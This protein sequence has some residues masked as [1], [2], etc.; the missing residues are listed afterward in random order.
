MLKSKLHDFGFDNGCIQ[1]FRSYLYGHSQ[2][3]KVDGVLSSPVMISSGVPKG[4]VMGLFRFIMFNIYLPDPI[5][6]QPYFFS[7][8]MI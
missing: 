2:S 5:G 4:S 7:K 8:V 3:A 1:L 6:T